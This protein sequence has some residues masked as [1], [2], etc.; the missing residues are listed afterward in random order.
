VSLFLGVA[1]AYRGDSEIMSAA[2]AAVKNLALNEDSVGQ[3]ASQGGLELIITALEAHPDNPVSESVGQWAGLAYDPSVRPAQHP[4]P[5][6]LVP[7]CHFC[8]A[9]PVGGRQAQED[10][11]HQWGRL[12]HAQGGGVV[13]PHPLGGFALYK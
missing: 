1:K 5:A 11:L 9:Q 2:L 4:I 3:I 7:D 8:D 10:A 6:G 12:A 13:A